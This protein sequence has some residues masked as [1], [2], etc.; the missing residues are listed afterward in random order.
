MRGGAVAGGRLRG[1][2]PDGAS[3]SRRE[4]LQV[5]LEETEGV[6]VNVHVEIG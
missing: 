4:G 1:R 6:R 3:C 5:C 2:P